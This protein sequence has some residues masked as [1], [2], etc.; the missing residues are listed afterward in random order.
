MTMCG[1]KEAKI[2]PKGQLDA[3]GEQLFAAQGLLRDGMVALVQSRQALEAIAAPMEAETAPERPPTAAPEPVSDPSD[4]H[5]LVVNGLRVQMEQLGLL[6][7]RLEAMESR[8]EAIE[9]RNPPHRSLEEAWKHFNGW[10]GGPIAGT[11]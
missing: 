10:V 2:S 3:V 5:G 4:P 1:C 7:R 6:S 11:R 9:A 8:F